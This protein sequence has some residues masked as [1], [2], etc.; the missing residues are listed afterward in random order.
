MSVF[1]DGVDMVAFG[2]DFDVELDGFAWRSFA[3][4]TKGFDAVESVQT[5][6]DLS[7]NGMLPVKM[8]RGAEADEELGAVGV[9]AGIG[10]GKDTTGVV[11]ELRREFVI[12]AIAWSAGARLAAHEVPLGIG[13]AALSHEALHNAV[14]RHAF[15]ETLFRK[16]DHIGDGVRDFVFIQFGDHVAF[17]SGDADGRIGLCHNLLAVDFLYVRHGKLKDIFADDDGD[18]VIVDSGGTFVGFTVL[19]LDEICGKCDGG[20]KEKQQQFFH[21]GSDDGRYY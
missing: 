1:L 6:D 5:F 12:E 15:I 4:R 17:G 14:E 19:Q 21:S 10:H 8:R 7:E 13:A 16:R 9:F 20:E 18:V 11:F 2:K 3:L